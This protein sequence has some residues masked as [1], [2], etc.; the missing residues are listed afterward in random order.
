MTVAPPSGSGPYAT[1]DQ[2]AEALRLQVTAKNAATLE[3]C[4]DAASTEIDQFLDRPAA[5]PLPIPPPALIVRVCVNRAVEWWK[6]ADA[7]FGALGFDGTG[8]LSAP[9]DGFARHGRDLI[10]FKSRFGVA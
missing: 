1:A 3:A 2:L 10:A 4:I 6:A 7:A 9:R 5:S 8:V